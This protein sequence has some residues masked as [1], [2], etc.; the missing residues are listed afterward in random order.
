MFNGVVRTL[1]GLLV[2]VSGAG[3]MMTTGGEADQIG[4]GSSIG[5]SPDASDGGDGQPIAGVSFVIANAQRG[6]ALDEPFEVL[7]ASASF[8]TAGDLATDDNFD[9]AT[10]GPCVLTMGLPP[11]PIEPPMV[12]PLD[13]GP[14]ATLDNGAAHIEVAAE[15]VGSYVPARDVLRNGGFSAGQSWTFAFPGGDDIGPFMV[16]ID[17]PAYLSLT[18]PDLEDP[19][20]AIDTNAPLTFA[21]RAAAPADQVEV[22]LAT[23]RTGERRTITCTFDDDGDA[24]I[25]VEAMQFLL[26]DAT[27]T[28]V[29]VTRRNLG[30]AEAPLVSGEVL[31]VQLFAQTIDGRLFVMPDEPRRRS[32][33]RR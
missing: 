23:S 21:W 12:E 16:S 6:V 32:N 5:D 3:C 14:A 19:N 28:T 1:I 2:C 31:P 22:L 4:S 7:I 25:P 8:F 15:D 10:S 17:L 29:Q 11:V 27:I 24:T 20:F 26:S 30:M 18:A 9:A 33:D 13:A